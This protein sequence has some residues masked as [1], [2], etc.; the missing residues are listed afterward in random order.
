MEKPA[1]TI[2]FDTDG[3]G[4]CLYGE[5]IDLQSLGSL[6][7]QRASHIEFNETTQQWEVLPPDGG[8]PMFSHPS[9]SQCLAWEHEHL[10]PQH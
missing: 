2:D 7:M 5:S 10:R 1:M 9:R 6:H 8:I 4:H 3:V